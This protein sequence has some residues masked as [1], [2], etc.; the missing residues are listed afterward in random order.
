MRA[1]RLITRA[2]TALAV[3]LGVAGLA[4]PAAM[5][6]DTAPVSRA[7]LIGSVPCDPPANIDLNILGVKICV[8]LG[9]PPLP[10]PAP[11]VPPVP[12]VPAPPIG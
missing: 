3:A 5:A 8:W 1:M 10:V 9:T 11:P 4:A 7:D 6:A 2:L 12:P